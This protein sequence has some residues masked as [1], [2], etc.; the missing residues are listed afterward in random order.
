MVLLPQKERPERKRFWDKDV[1]PLNVGK[2]PCFCGNKT[3][4]A[5]FA[6]SFRG[7]QERP[8][9]MQKIPPGHFFKISLGLPFFVV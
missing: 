1:M 5:Y 8:P 6:R 3:I 9:H 2:F 4:G 7:G